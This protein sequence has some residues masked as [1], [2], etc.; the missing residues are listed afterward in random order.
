MTSQTNLPQTSDDILYCLRV[1]MFIACLCMGYELSCPEPADTETTALS[2]QDVTA[3]TSKQRIWS[4]KAAR[5]YAEAQERQWQRWNEAM[6][7]R[8]A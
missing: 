6:F 5:A 3:P 8:S 4:D 7:E 1:L 2:L